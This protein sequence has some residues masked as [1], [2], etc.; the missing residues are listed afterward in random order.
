MRFARR[1]RGL[2]KG[3]AFVLAGLERHCNR[4]LPHRP[5]LP[6][7][8]GTGEH[9]SLVVRHPVLHMLFASA[10][11]FAFHSSLINLKKSQ[12]ITGDQK[13]RHFQFAIRGPL[14]T[15]RGFRKPVQK[16]VVSSS[17]V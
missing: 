10:R 7:S 16:K 5:R 9:H 17:L 12:V 15:I 14:Q 8:S 13:F 1:L 2:V 4:A 11:D 3:R 6:H